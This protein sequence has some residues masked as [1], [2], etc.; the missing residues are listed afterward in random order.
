MK[1]AII[2]SAALGLFFAATPV[3]SGTPPALT[4]GGNPAHTG[5]YETRPLTELSGV[6]WRYKTGGAI[7][8][9]PAIHDGVAGTG[10]IMW[11]IKSE[12][13]VYSYP[14]IAGSVLYWGSGDHHVY[15]ISLKSGE[16]LWKFEAGAPAGTPVPYE[17]K[18]LLCAGSNLFA[19][20]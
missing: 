10:R 1:L 12:G 9:A 17:G 7:C 3:T 2:A 20:E 8:G 6:K 19:L 15:A 4:H 13:T 16:V 5:V 18:V 11:D 14:S